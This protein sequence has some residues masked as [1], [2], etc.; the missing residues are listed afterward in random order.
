MCQAD[1]IS[2][3]VKTLVKQGGNLASFSNDRDGFEYFVSDEFGHLIPAPLFR[4]PIQLQ[5]EV[6][7]TVCV[8][9][10]AVGGRRAV[11]RKLLSR[12][13]LDS[14]ELFFFVRRDDQGGT[15]DLKLIE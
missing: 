8:E 6:S 9:S 4:H 14:A 13:F 10:E 5:M 1:A 12:R 3:S 7:P 15:N 2:D 11:E